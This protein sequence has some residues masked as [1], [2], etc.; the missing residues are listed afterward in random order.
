MGGL[1]V[2][3]F[4]NLGIGRAEQVQENE[5]GKQQ[6]QRCVA[7][8]E[9]ISTSMFL[10]TGERGHGIS[11]SDVDIF[12]LFLFSSDCLSSRNAPICN[13]RQVWKPE[14]DINI[15]T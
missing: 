9:A 4:L 15:V 8:R 14:S 10:L 1:D 3:G 12:F 11:P 2:E 7:C 13:A 6:I 5:R